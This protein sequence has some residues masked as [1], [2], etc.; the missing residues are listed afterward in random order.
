M[1]LTFEDPPIS[2]E[3]LNVD[4]FLQSFIV[5]G[6]TS[7]IFLVLK[8]GPVWP[9]GKIVFFIFGHLQQLKSAP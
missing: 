6:K 5:V 1:Y 4:N 2:F 9:D 8:I 3:L 7:T